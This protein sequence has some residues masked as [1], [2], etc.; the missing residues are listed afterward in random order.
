MGPPKDVLSAFGIT[1]T[2]TH[3]SGGQG[4]TFLAGQ[5]ILKPAPNPTETAWIADT[6]SGIQQA[7]FRLAKH[8][9]ATSGDW[10]VSGWSAQSLLEGDHRHE[11]WPEIIAVGRD[12]HRAMIEIARPAF[13]DARVDRWAVAD[14]VAWGEKS[15]DPDLTETLAPALKMLRPVAQP[16]QLIHGDLTGN[17]LFM[18]D[19]SPAVIDFTPYWRPA[20]FAAAVVV[21]DAVTW[22][23]AGPSLFSAVE[24]LPEIDQLLLRAAV[25]RLVE[26]AAQ[27]HALGRTLASALNRHRVTLDLLTTRF[28]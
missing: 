20:G 14:R 21:V 8:K 28:A 23:N 25:W 15:H 27:A 5:W 24:A 11:A 13:L 9:R 7:G 18:E 12:L 3:V 22:E 2:L 6:I 17:V 26:A 16:D 1:D 19:Q 4:Q 10:V